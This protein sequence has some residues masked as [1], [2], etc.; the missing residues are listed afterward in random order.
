MKIN[1]ILIKPILTEKATNLVK[2]NYYTFEVNTKSNKFQVKQAVEN[3]YKVKIDSIKINLKKGKVKKVGKKMI[4]RR[5]PD[6][7]VVYI[8]LKEGKI[9]IF[10]QT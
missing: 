4:P 5:L 8:K 9:D 10:P 7:K 2:D 3:L 1:A 6:R